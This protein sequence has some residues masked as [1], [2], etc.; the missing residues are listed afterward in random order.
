LQ[1]FGRT[2][3]V[4]SCEDLGPRIEAFGARVHTVDGHDPVAIA[5]A[6]NAAGR[7]VPMVLILDTVKGKGLHFEDSLESHYLPLKP[8]EYLA[9]RNALMKNGSSS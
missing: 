4:I 2:R 8:V 5:E 1:G 7:G 6:L 3:D 9:A